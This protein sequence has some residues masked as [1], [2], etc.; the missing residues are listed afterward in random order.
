MS[1]LDIITRSGILVIS[2]ETIADGS[3][4]FHK[5]VLELIDT[6]ISDFEDF[7]RVAFETRAF[8]TTGGTQSRRIALMNEQQATLLMTFQ[9]NTELVRTFKKALVRS[10]FN[11]AR[12]LA[13]APAELT[14]MQILELAMESEQRAIAATARAEVAEEFK[15]AIEVADGLTSRQF[16]KHYLSEVSERVFFEL[17]YKRGLLIDQ[18]GQ[19]S[20][21]NGKPKSGRQ[22]G[23]PSFTGKAYFYLH[24]TVDRDGNRFENTRVRPGAPELALVEYCAKR[25]LIPNRTKDLAHV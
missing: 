17:M 4:V 24:P 14:R 11:M 15:E 16:H 22:H 19:R 6:N 21:A 2:S 3:G 9:R 18:R 10:F 13:P 23:H 5:N 1:A 8:E 7:G 12:Q 20:D 25:G